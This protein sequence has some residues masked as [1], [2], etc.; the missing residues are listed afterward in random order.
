MVFK[1]MRCHEYHIRS[2]IS[3][4]Y[5]LIIRAYLSMK[6]FRVCCVNYNFSS[7]KNRTCL[8]FQSQAV[9]IGHKCDYADELVKLRRLQGGAKRLTECTRISCRAN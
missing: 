8:V 5:L 4:K 3:Y 1:M 9:S 7:W 6:K 2:L